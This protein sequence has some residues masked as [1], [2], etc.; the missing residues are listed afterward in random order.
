MRRI[1]MPSFAVLLALAALPVRAG[2]HYQATTTPEGPGDPEATSVEAWVEGAKAKIVFRESG[3]PVLEAGQY[4]LT[5]D[6]GKTLF[7]VDPEEET[8]A[9]WN[10]EA[11]LQAIGAVMQGMQPLLNLSIDDVEVEKL[12]DE[13]GGELLG[14]PVTHTRHR[15]S[16]A[17]NI[18]VLGMSRSNRVE[19]V[20]DTWSTAAL[21]DVALGVWLRSAPATGFEDLDDLVQAEMGKVQGFPLKT[22]AVTTTTGQK[23]KREST[24]TTT[25]E[26]TLL[27]TA[28]SV[29]D[30]TFVIPEGYERV[31]I[32]P[33]EE[34]EEG[35]PLRGIFGGKG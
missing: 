10:L 35:N 5:T 7:L 17:M 1:A 25:T 32:A 30:A 26:V 12:A 24:T 16:Y 19:T 3:A 6:G 4:L 23:G 18:K 31:E 20:Q 28:V 2:I 15:T 33:A 29:P 34:G 14:L 9:E 27:E 11:M 8:Y 13:P 22:V 21:E